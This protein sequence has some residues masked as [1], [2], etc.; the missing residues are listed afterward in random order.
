MGAKRLAAVLA[1][2]LLVAGAIVLRNFVDSGGEVTLGRDASPVVCDPL[3]FEA[4]RAAFPDRTVTR[5]DP[6]VTLDRLL[7]ERTTDPFL[8]VTADVWPQ[9]LA[10]RIVRTNP[11]GRSETLATTDLVLVAATDRAFCEE[12]TWACLADEAEER[13]SGLDIG[14]E[15]P[16]TTLGLLTRGNLVAG[17]F[18][19]TD[20]SSNDFATTE[21]NQ[22]WS[23]ASKALVPTGGVTA[24]NLLAT[25][26]GS[27][28]VAPASRVSFDAIVSPRNEAEAPGDTNRSVTIVGV[29]IADAS[30]R[31]EALID[32]LAD[33]GWG[34]PRPETDGAVVTPG[35]LQ[36]LRS[37]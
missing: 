12:L 15:G 6:G 20:F 3:V 35:V 28:D 37:R 29:A 5:E 22:W 8:W 19:R 11:A 27:L 16:D 24:L 1:A 4:C 10:D 17:Y 14:L 2:L 9:I 25:R 23:S 34:G 18:G 33:R 26:Q 21:F 7:S 36:A 32:E 30:G 31:A 13:G